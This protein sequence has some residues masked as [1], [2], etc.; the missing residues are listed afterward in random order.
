MID[1][2]VLATWMDDIFA[3]FSDKT[4][5]FSMAAVGTLLFTLRLV[6]MLI[7]GMDAGGDF[8]TGIDADAG[9]ADLHGGDFSLFSMVSILAFLMGA[10]WL[11]LTCRLEWDV[12]PVLSAIYASLFGFGLMLL[13]SFALWQMRRLSESGRYDLQNCVGHTGRVY[14]RIPERGQGRGQVQITVDGT[15]KVVDAVS[16]GEAIESFATVR[17]TAVEE[18]ETLLVERA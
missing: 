1:A 5:Y 4:I 12:G 11:G 3:V 2:G 16:T 8:D 14:L 13:S 9:G 18:G 10:G 17:V 7:G 6:L 15:Q